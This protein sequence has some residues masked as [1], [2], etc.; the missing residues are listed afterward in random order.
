MISRQPSLRVAILRNYDTP[1]QW[2]KE[3]IESWKTSIH[4]IRPDSEIE[5]F[6]PITDGVFPNPEDFDLIILT[7]GVFDLTL[8]DFDPWVENTLEYV[9]NTAKL[10]SGPKL[11][12][13]CW[14]HQVICWAMGGKI[15]WN[16]QGDVVGVQE[17]RC[18]EAGV[19]FFGLDKGGAKSGN[20]AL[21]KF[22]KRSIATPPPS[23]TALAEDHEV[24]LSSDNKMITF[25]GHPEMTNFVAKG[26]LDAD[27]GAYT[28]SA[29]EAQ[30][31]EMYARFE[32][33]HDGVPVPHRLIKWLDEQMLQD[34]M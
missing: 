3:M 9:R 23:F 22:H 30:V 1:A 25:Q 21:H 29:T 33:P 4:A 17:F 28:G 13:I 32:L 27:D 15:G 18:T 8:P 31:K 34:R 19:K 10:E 16:R 14:G 11:A 12:G 24:L 5:V 6:H 20:L 2:G 26:I 7:G